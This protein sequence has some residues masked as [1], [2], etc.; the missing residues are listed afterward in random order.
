MT[1]ERSPSDESL[2]RYVAGSLSAGPS[3]V[4]A[5][6][7]ETCRSCRA[8]VAEFVCVGAAL[9][10]DAPQAPMRADALARTLERLERPD[11]PRG[12]EIPQAP[13]RAELGIPLPASLKDCEVGPWR[14]LAPGFRRSRI[15]V[16]GAPEANVMLLRGRPGLRLPAHGHVGTEFT[17]VLK[18]RL[19]DERGV[20]GPGDFDEADSGLDHE[21]V[22]GED[23]ECI[24]LAALEGGMRMH[25]RIGRV[26]GSLLGF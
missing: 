5:S 2:L 22:V 9:L 20:F 14:W 10:E 12:A 6:H 15:T 24:C 26:L 3:L 17:L 11:P 18:G 21:P 19:R 23:G 13:R 16:P 1:P 4:I 8:R 25:G 7:L